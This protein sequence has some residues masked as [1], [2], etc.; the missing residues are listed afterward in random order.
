MYARVATFEGSDRAKMA[1]GVEAIKRRSEGREHEPPEGVP[2]I[3]F[4]L[5]SHTEEAKTLSITLY[6]T[7]E[8]L[9]TGDAALNAMDRPGSGPAPTKTVDVYEVALKVER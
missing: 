1:E 6:E 8:D 7:E 5:L 2:A 9:R 3:G 4:L